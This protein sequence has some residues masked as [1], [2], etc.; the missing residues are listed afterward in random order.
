MSI[1]FSSRTRLGSD[2]ASP[3]ESTQTFQSFPATTYSPPSPEELLELTI[4]LPSG[5]IINIDSV[6]TTDPEITSC[7]ASGSGS[8]S[9]NLEFWSAASS[10]RIIQD[11]QFSSVLKDK[12]QKV[13]RRDRGYSSRSAPETVVPHGG[14]TIDPVVLRR[15]LTHR[16]SRNGSCT[17]RAIHGLRFISSK[18]NG[19][20]GW[21]EVREKFANLSK[22]G[23]LCR[24]D[25]AHCIGSSFSLVSCFV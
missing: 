19:I 12:L 4:D 10:H 16:F 13:S 17:Q 21:R 1:S 20:A 6:S 15:S 23:Y 18:E 3:G 25:F 9:A 2:L 5:V 14:E 24:S 11:T 8:L 7:S 22:D